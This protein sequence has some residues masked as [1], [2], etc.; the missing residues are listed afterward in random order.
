MELKKVNKLVISD[1]VFVIL[2]YLDDH[3]YKKLYKAVLTVCVV[4]VV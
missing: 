2:G 1:N 3:V 4:L